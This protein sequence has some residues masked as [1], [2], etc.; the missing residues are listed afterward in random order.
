M[1]PAVPVPRS[2][3]LRTPLEIKLKPGWGFDPARR[4]FVSSAGEIFTPGNDLPK[5]SKIV[6]K[7]PAIAEAARSQRTPLS[8]AE[9]DL[10]R[11]LQL[12]LPAQ[13]PPT[14]LLSTVRA[15]PPVEEVFLPPQ[16]SLP[17]L[18]CAS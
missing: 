3:R 15:W 5:K 16:V 14:D 6:L 4:V 18:S 8:E 17:V 2:A 11:Y 7:T 10:L 9:E 13:K 1:I 12:I